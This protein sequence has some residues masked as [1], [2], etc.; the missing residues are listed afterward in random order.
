M[1]EIIVIDDGRFEVHAANCANAAYQQKVKG[2]GYGW[3]KFPAGLERAELAADLLQDSIEAGTV[4]LRDYNDWV[5]F[6]DCCE[7]ERD[8]NSADQHTGEDRNVRRGGHGRSSGVHGTNGTGSTQ[9]RDAGPGTAGE[10]TKAAQFAADAEAAGWSIGIQTSGDLVTVTATRDAEEIE[11]SWKGEAC[12]NGSTY[13]NGGYC[14]SMRNAAA[15]RRQM[16]LAAGQ[17]T[18]PSNRRA[19]R[20]PASSATAED[21]YEESPEDADAFRLELPFQLD[22]EAEQILKLLLGKMITWKSS[23]TR[24]LHSAVILP[25]ADQ[26][27]IQI[28]EHPKNGKRILTFAAKGEGFRS[29]YLESI[30]AVL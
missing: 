23:L 26:N 1:R 30:V 7:E 13:R 2:P 21:S 19:R 15:C 17:A 3:A 24:N 22:D 4:R 10:G 6:P 9:P 8:G 11:I 18:P 20:R 16:S 12:Q 14:K 27:H 5:R 25:N 29:V 28:E